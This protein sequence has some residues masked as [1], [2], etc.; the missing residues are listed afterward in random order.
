MLQ[1]SPGHE[2]GVD[3]IP[4]GPVHVGEAIGRCHEED[5]GGVHLVRQVT[6]SLVSK[7]CRGGADLVTA[8]LTNKNDDDKDHSPEH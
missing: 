6:A 8:S 1:S 4:Q 7:H 3:G 2:A 5:Q